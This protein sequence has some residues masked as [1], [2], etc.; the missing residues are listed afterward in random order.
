MKA[1]LGQ[2]HAS[3]A[4]FGT[5]ISYSGSARLALAAVL[6]AAAAASVWLGRRL[7]APLR[8][9]RPGPAVTAA[10]LATWA[11][12]ITAFLVCAHV[13]VQQLRRDH[14]L[15]AAP[16][17]PIAP[18]TLVCAG[19]LF[20][21]LVIT[22]AHKPRGWATA[23]IAAMAAPM[24]FELPFD[25]IVMART[26]PAVPPDPAAYRVLFFAPLFL[27]EITTL[28]LL[29]LSPQVQVSRATFACFALM[30]AV[31]AAW[32][33]SGFG[34]PDA[35]VPVLLNATSKVLAF[36]TT[37]TLFLPL[38]AREATLPAAPWTGMLQPVSPGGQDA[39]SRPCTSPPAN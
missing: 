10:L 12:A 17:D 16:T 15:Q 3:A 30:L 28:A 14:L 24:V 21:V 19:V 35:P 2:A 37:L 9:V 11:T 33:L 4:Q 23:A 13:Y 39:R 6:L 27:I 34:Y 18:V 1:S 31:F 25:L 22:G 38:R 5:W 20:A 26:C 36:V 32:S 29:A 7:P 8:P